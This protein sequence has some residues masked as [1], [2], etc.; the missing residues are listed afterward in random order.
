[1]MFAR[2]NDITLAYSDRGTGIPLVL[3]HAFPL[4][5]SMWMPQELELSQHCRVIAI[6]LRGHGES[7]AP[8]WRYTLEQSADDVKGL[9]D[10]LAVKQ[11]VL[12][13]LSMGGYIL[14]AIY[15]KYPALAK[16]LIFADTRAEPDKP[17]Q[18]AWRFQ[19]AQRVYKQGSLAV[20][21][22]MLPKLLHPATAQH[23][24]ALVERVRHMILSTQISGVV[25]DL[26]AIAERPDSTPL[27]SQISCPTLVIAGDGDVLT[28]P[29]ENERI[30]NG[31][32][33]ARF[34]LIPKAGHLCNLEQP[35]AFNRAV[36][37]FLAALR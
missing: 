6:D 14:L 12:A 9:L 37:D 10:H 17:E 34:H 18:V 7:D 32:P 21:D 33:G 15:R 1:M 28:L 25:G 22:E 2:I 20:A 4:N 8:L 31:I 11:A 35:E 5:R 24:P 3:L 29:A 23:H 16:G 30:A 13:G 27:L 36:I 26:M 19:L